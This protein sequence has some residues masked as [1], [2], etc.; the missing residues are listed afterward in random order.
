MADA[1]LGPIPVFMRI[2]DGDE[3]EIGT[4]TP[5]VSEMERDENGAPFVTV[6]VA[7]PVSRLLPSLLRSAADEMERAGG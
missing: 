5:E 7:A 6:S 4:I 2:G 3:C 1:M